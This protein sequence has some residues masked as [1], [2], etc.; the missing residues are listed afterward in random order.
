MINVAVIGVGFMGERHA[1]TFCKLPGVKLRA[2]CDRNAETSMKVAKTFGARPYTSYLRMLQH[3]E[4]D[5]VSIATPTGLH[6]EI[7]ITTAD[8]VKQRKWFELQI[9]KRSS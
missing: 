9:A 4:L 1:E 8:Y 7:M 5:A 2:V 3:E 6:G